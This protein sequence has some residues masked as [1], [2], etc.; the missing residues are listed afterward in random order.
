M[1][2]KSKIHG[3]VKVGK[4]GQVVIPA[5]LRK[6][7]AIKP[8]DRLLVFAQADK[9]IISLMPEKYFSKLLGK[10]GDKIYRGL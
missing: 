8:R 5:K 1:R 7:F 9:K 6:S 4:R 2:F 3:A 10:A